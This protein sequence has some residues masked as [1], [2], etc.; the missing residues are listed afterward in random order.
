MKTAGKL[1]EVVEVRNGRKVARYD[2]KC[3]P[4]EEDET[5]IRIFLLT[6]FGRPPVMTYSVESGG[7]P[8][9]ARELAERFAAEYASQ[10]G[11]ALRQK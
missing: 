4:F 8:K 7:T 2:V 6:D 5:G 11:G 9:K 10:V 1:V 3:T